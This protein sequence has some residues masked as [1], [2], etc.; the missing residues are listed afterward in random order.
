M[1]VLILNR[2]FRFEN[3]EEVIVA[4]NCVES[5]MCVICGN[6]T[7]KYKLI[8]AEGLQVM[9]TLFRNAMKFNNFVIARKIGMF[10]EKDKKPF[11]HRSCYSSLATQRRDSGPQGVK[12][13]AHQAFKKVADIIENNVIKEQN[14]EML[15][16]LKNI[17]DVE[18]RRI[19]DDV[20][21]TFK[22]DYTYR[23]QPRIKKHFN[24][25]VEIKSL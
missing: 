4:E 7:K 15:H 25:R 17:F 18:A 12:Q 20:R 19:F 11:Y 8:N 14:F 24:D 1:N 10:A 21:L 2:C 6:G 23:L 16:D 3:Q 9:H 5:E 13:Y 22:K